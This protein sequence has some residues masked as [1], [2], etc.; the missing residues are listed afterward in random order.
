M[1]RETFKKTVKL[2]FKAVAKKASG[3]KFGGVLSMQTFVEAQNIDKET[4]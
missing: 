2:M 3:E 4:F 1:Q